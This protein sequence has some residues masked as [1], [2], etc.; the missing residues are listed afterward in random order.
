M[1]WDVTC[2]ENH[3]STWTDKDIY[4]CKNMYTLLS[5]FRHMKTE[6]QCYSSVTQGHT[7]MSSEV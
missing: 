1:C 5:S 6:D 7:P 2:D 4:A 3:M